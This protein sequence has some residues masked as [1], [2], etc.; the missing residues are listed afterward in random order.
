MSLTPEALRAS[1]AS[2]KQVLNTAQKPQPKATEAAESVKI[3]RPPQYHSKNDNA[4]SEFQNEINRFTED[5]LARAQYT[6][7]AQTIIKKCKVNEPLDYIKKFIARGSDRMQG[8][9]NGYYPEVINASE[10]FTRDSPPLPAQIIRYLLHQGSKMLLGGNSKGRKTWALIDV[11]IS[12]ACGAEWWGFPVSMGSVCYI[13]LEIQ[14]Q[15]FEH[16]F[17]K[18][19]EVKGVRP[20]SGM[21]YVWN[22]RGY[23]KPMNQLIQALLG[24]LKQHHFVL[25]IIDPIYKTL[26]AARGSE[27]DS[28]MITQ[29]LNDVES[30]A[31]QTG[32]AVLFSSHFSK[33][34]QAEKE[35]MDRISGSGAWARD[36]DSLL[37]MTPHEES[38]C[39]TV[40]ATL[41]NLAPIRS[42]V[43]KWDYP[44]FVRHEELN[45]ERLKKRG[46]PFQSQPEKLLAVLNEFEGKKPGAV[47]AEMDE[48]YGLKSSSVHRMKDVLIERGE[49]KTDSAGL[50]Y[51]VVPKSQNV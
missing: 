3:V 2:K 47:L 13:N 24:F 6:Q 7:F 9:S 25:I 14:P 4:A 19:C 17:L 29:L 50:W 31:V 16:R 40:E 37:T 1:F 28:A 48:Q 18:V 30:I 32:A 51:K 35:S 34:N 8:S 44:L 43:V 45:P 22:L 46:R 33:G 39:F 11:G 26:P 38:D 20:E 5:Q 23:A 15:F 41:R 36:P 42:F 27:N 21:F 12:V 49:F 10:F